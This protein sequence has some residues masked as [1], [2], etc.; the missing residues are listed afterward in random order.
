MGRKRKNYYFT[1]VT[2]KAIIRYNNE[3]RP[4]MRNRIYNDHIKD[5]FDKLCENIIHTFKFYYFDV[6]S[7]EVKNEVVSFLVMNMH[8]YTAGKGKAFSYFSIVAKN[9]LILHNNNNYKK[10]KT[11]DKIDVMDWDRSIQAEISQKDTDSSYKEFVSQM[12][13]YWDNNMNVIF[14]RQKDVRVADAVL[15]IFRI[16]GSI[17][18]FNKKALYIL[19]REMTQ[20]N[21]QHITRVINVMK[22]YQKGIYKEFQVNGFIDTKTT[23]SF[24]IHN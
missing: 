24:V 6:S 19:I 10:M 8:K 20:S 4:F 1:D 17:E 3:E 18:L 21:T 2:E 7:E 11:H 22:K 23:G 5:A 9:Y 13:E 14:R 16:K 12:L 15:H